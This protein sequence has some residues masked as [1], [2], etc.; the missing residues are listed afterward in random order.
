M[1]RHFVKRLCVHPR[2]RESGLAC[3]QKIRER[4]L[5]EANASSLVNVEFIEEC[6]A[7]CSKKKRP[8]NQFGFHGALIG[9]TNLRIV[10]IYKTFRW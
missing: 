6:I 4:Q 9:A 8:S 2:P 5:A 10:N 1:R 7:D 3:E